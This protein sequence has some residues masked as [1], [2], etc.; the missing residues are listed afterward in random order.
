MNERE[1]VNRMDCGQ[2]EEVVH[3]L[4]RPGTPGLAMRETA[5]GHAEA[6][7][8]CARLMTEAESLDF[9]LQSLAVRDASSHAPPHIE[10]SLIREF[11]RQKAAS[12]RRRMQWGMAALG[13]VAAV[14]L[15]LGISLRHAGTPAAN[16]RLASGVSAEVAGTSPEGIEVAENQSNDSENATAFVSLPYATDPETLEGGAVVRVLL[17]RSA[18]AS[19]GL[20]VANMEATE[21]IP[22]DIV[23]SEDGAPQ[24]IRLVSQAQVDYSVAAS[25]GGTNEP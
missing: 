22:A 4:D 13:T 9:S 25:L 1:E 8:R 11:R 3:D 23:L 10:S 14:L 17:S 2:F 5:L 15:A 6:C 12:S 18:L 7:S 20:P 19:L 16:T 24:S 21:Q